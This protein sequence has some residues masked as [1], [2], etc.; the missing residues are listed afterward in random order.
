[1]CIDVFYRTTIRKFWVFTKHYSGSA[2]IGLIVLD[3]NRKDTAICAITRANIDGYAWFLPLN[4]FF[5]SQKSGTG[6]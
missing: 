3:A 5:L 6:T 1:M 2:A 4:G